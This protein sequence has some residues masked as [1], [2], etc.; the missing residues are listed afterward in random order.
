MNADVEI[1]IAE[2]ENVFTIPWDAVFHFEN[3]DH[4]AVKRPDSSF[5]WREV[6]LG[7]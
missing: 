4:V 3:K 2:H 6:I 5:A 7:A 1:L